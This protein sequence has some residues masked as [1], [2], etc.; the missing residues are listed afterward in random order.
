M[1]RGWAV[2][3]LLM[4]I[5]SGCLSDDEAPEETPVETGVVTDEAEVRFGPHSGLP[6]TLEEA[7]ERNLI[8]PPQWVLGEWWTIRLTSFFDGKVTETTR[9]VSGTEGEDFLVGMPKDTFENEVMVLHV[10]GFGLVDKETLGF[11]AHDVFFQPLQFPLVESASWNAD[12]QAPNGLTAVVDRVEGNKAFI[13][14]S[15]GFTINMTYD[16][17]MGAISRMYIAG[18]GLYEVIA[19]GFDYEGMVTVPYKHD[20]IFFNG[21]LAVVGDLSQP[22]FPTPS[23]A[24]PMETITI[25]D[26]YD[27]VSFSLIMG[28]ILTQG[29]VPVDPGFYDIDV[30]A[31]DGTLYEATKTPADGAGVTITSFGHDQ[32]GG[33]WEIMSV[34]AGPGVSFIEGIAYIV[35]D[36][37]LPEGCVVLT[38][39]IHDHGGECGGHV[40]GLE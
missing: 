39:R 17:D 4:L 15:G 31:P 11:E 16:A 32:P 27:R 24:P 12:F 7:G 21:R 33:D 25:P 1:K 13:D 9:I 18:Y 40:H 37:D 8:E 5:I 20:L 10:P 34:A 35:Y 36:V 29:Q 22:L 19:H 23:P 26:E 2:A 3:P 14:M 30:T 38:Q 28:D 6:R